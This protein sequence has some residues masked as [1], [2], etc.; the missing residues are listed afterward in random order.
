MDL[1]PPLDHRLIQLDNVIVT[2]H[3]AFFSQEA[4][5]ELEERAA[6]EVVRV[7]QGRMP[8]NLVNPAVLDHARVKL[9]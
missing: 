5:L 6:A 2:P 7:F 8:D 3:T 9:T 1:D 4:V